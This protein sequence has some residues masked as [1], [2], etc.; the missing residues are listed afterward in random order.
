MCSVMSEVMNQWFGWEMDG[1]CYASDAFKE[2]H[3]IAH[4]WNI[5]PDGR[6][7]DTT[8][9]QFR[10]GDTPDG[11]RV[12]PGDDPRYMGWCEGDSCD[13]W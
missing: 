5:L 11:I 13:P 10:E 1:G 6:I 7:I 8:A 2:G 3:H 4:V 9:D 12:V